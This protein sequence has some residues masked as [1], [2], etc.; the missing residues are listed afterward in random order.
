MRNMDLNVI[1]IGHMPLAAKLPTDLGDGY[2]VK[3]VDI[4]IPKARFKSFK[5]KEPI[6]YRLDE[7]KREVRFPGGHFD[8]VQDVCTYLNLLLKSDSEKDAIS[9][10]YDR[11]L[12]KVRVTCTGRAAVKLPLTMCTA[13]GLPYATLRE[14]TLGSIVSYNEGR[15]YG[16][17]T[18]DALENTL[19]N[20]QYIPLLT[21]MALDE[22]PRRLDKYLKM[23]R[24]AG[25]SQIRI[26]LRDTIDGSPITPVNGD[27]LVAL[28]IRKCT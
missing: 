18:C 9:F 7:D 5:T 28:H 13:L 16:L 11:Y 4:H 17:L 8:T 26:E 1:L 24:L 21:A 14:T 15:E 3:L 2:E 20:R 12:H 19:I 25:V 23:R 10:Y 22:K 6:S 27:C